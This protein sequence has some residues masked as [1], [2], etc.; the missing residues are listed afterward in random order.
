M[1]AC[2]RAEDVGLDFSGGTYGLD[3]LGKNVYGFPWDFW[4][5]LCLQFWEVTSL[6]LFNKE[7]KL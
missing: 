5:G 4:K 3:F 6:P 1:L 7:I 2:V